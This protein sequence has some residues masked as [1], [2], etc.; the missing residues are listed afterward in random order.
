MTIAWISRA[1]SSACATAASPISQPTATVRPARP[2]AR[3]PSAYSQREHVRVS[4]DMGFRLTSPFV[5]H[6][7]M[8]NSLRIF[9]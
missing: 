8:V 1:S 6:Y 5:M 7:L 9:S 2:A 3:R 4:A